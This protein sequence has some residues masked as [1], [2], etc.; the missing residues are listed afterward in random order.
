MTTFQIKLLAITTMLIDH[1]G[2]YLMGDYEP[3]RIIGRLAFPLFAWLVANGAYYTKDIKKYFLRLLVFAAVAQIP[4]MLLNQKTFP[5][6]VSQNALFTLALG[7]LAV[8]I[9]KSSNN[10]FIWIITSVVISLFAYL[11]KTE[12]GAAGVLSVLAFYFFFRD[13]KLMAISQITIFLCFYFVSIPGL[14]INKI[15]LI[16][17]TEIFGLLSLFIIAAYNQ[18]EGKKMR[19]IFYWFYPAQLLFIYI[20]R[21]LLFKY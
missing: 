7:L 11:F 9:I 12:Y 17:P 19:Y 21:L 14:F 13:I 8:I 20:V 3:L 4:F 10:K 2:L 15:I 1:V 18:H 6:L 5:S 16:K